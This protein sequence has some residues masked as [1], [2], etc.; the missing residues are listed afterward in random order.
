LAVKSQGG[1]KRTSVRTT[2]DPC[3]KR[4]PLRIDSGKVKQQPTGGPDVVAGGSVTPSGRN[5]VGVKSGEKATRIEERT[6]KSE[7][8]RVTMPHGSNNRREQVLPPAGAKGVGKWKRKNQPVRSEKTKVKKNF[9]CCQR[10]GRRKTP[11]K[12][13][14][15]LQVKTIAPN[16]FEQ[17]GQG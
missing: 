8:R 5:K 14:I 16:L 6:G 1:R 7:P 3:H 10:G 15:K 17:T 9:S 12:V 2:Y 11:G 13:F 4:Q